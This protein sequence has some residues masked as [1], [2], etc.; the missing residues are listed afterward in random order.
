VP[1]RQDLAMGGPLPGYC[2]SFQRLPPETPQRLIQ[3]RLGRVHRR[4][5]LPAA[6]ECLFAFE[7]AAGYLTPE[8]LE[9]VERLSF[10]DPESGLELRLQVNYARS[11]YGASRGGSGGRTA[12][13][14]QLC[15]R[16]VGAPG[17]ERLRVY[18]F[19]LTPGREGGRPFFLQ[20]TPFPL[21]PFHFVLILSE[22]RPQL[23][24]GRSIQDMLDF[25]RLAPG[26][27][28]C[29]NSDVEWAGSSILD[30]LH[31]QVFRSLRLPVM[32]ARAV[33]GVE[34]PGLVLEALRYPLSAL[35]I[36]GGQEQAV[37]AAVTH[38]VESW[39]SR[40]PGRNTVNLVLWRE[41]AT[42]EYCFTVL[43]RNPDHRTPPELRPFKS[44]GVGVIEASGEAILPVPTGPEA[45]ARWR[46]I[47]HDGLSIVRGIIEG[48]S[49]KVPPEGLRRLLGELPL[50]NAPL[51]D[52]PA[53]DPPLGNPP[54]GDGPSAEPHGA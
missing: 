10:P 9:E 52:P 26:Y 14:C 5:G 15:R 2:R 43:L 41:A 34:P 35:R 39:K 36:R 8:I 19:P 45:E 37:G 46:R 27:T 6:M 32:D 51:G 18:E 40:D 13:A 28:V 50:G 4:R 1:A 16:N 24:D 31:Y 21:Y 30:H 20:L 38:L 29:S 48:N 23:I 3:R 44:E 22:H 49:P 11:R 17:K 53:G 47:R 25:L 12:G 7:L 42:G 33:E 54:S